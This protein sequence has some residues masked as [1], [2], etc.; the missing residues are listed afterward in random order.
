MY[1]DYRRRRGHVVY[2]CVSLNSPLAYKQHYLSLNTLVGPSTRH[3][4]QKK[5]KNLSS[6]LLLN[7]G[8][9]CG[10]GWPSL[11]QVLCGQSRTRNL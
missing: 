2:L 11:L 4:K 9:P 5:E 6:T 8:I 3:I 1:S 10:G 7:K